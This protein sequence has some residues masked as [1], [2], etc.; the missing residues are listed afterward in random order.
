MHCGDWL[1]FRHFPTLAESSCTRPTSAA[2]IV[3]GF[4][5]IRR[6]ARMMSRYLDRFRIV[7]AKEPDLHPYLVT[8]TIKNGTDL[9][10]SDYSTSSAHSRGSTSADLV[11]DLARS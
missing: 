6:G 2:C 1:S 10:E 7:R 4:C 5:A 11:S 9:L 8:F 3:C